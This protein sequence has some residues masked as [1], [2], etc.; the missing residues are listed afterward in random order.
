M[1]NPVLKR[2]VKDAKR[3]QVPENYVKRV[4]QFARQGYTDIDF[5]VYDTDWDSEA[6]L[7]VSG[8]NSNN[9]VRAH[10]RIPAKPSRIRRRAGTSSGATARSNAIYKTREVARPVGARSAHAA[11]AFG[12]SG[13]AVPHLDQRLAHLPGVRAR[14]T[15]V[16]SVLG[17][18][19]PRRHRLQSG[20]DEP[21]C[22]FRDEAKT[23]QIAPVRYG[24]LSSMRRGS[25]PMVL[26]I[27]VMMAQFPSKEIARAVLRIPHAWSGLRQSRRPADV[28]RAYSYDSDEGRAICRRAHRAS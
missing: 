6:Y 16:Q 28:R 1:K 12:R 26:E 18:H 21:A 5:P 19:V 9:T 4:I 25:G 23:N 15:R 7:T 17:I 24:R 3:A 2:A 14:F 11:W 20:V 22:Q 8:Q 10:R 13:P 27:S